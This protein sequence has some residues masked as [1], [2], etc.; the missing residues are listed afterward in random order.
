MAYSNI[1]TKSI[2]MN[3]D[4]NWQNIQHMDKRERKLFIKQVVGIS[5]TNCAFITY[6]AKIHF[7][8]LIHHSECYFNNTGTSTKVKEFEELGWYDSDGHLNPSKIISHI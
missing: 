5:R 4:M 2:L 6:G 8:H 3:I 1:L 7:A